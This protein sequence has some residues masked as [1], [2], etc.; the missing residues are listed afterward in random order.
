MAQFAV[1]LK[2]YVPAVGYHHVLMILIAIAIVLLCKSYTHTTF[3]HRRTNIPFSITI[4]R[5]FIDLSS[6]T[7]DLPNITLLPTLRTCV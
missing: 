7:R 6:H 1:G 2:R 5:L 4:S 3:L